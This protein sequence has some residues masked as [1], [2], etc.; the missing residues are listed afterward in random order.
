MSRRACR[1]TRDTSHP[2][3]EQSRGD[4]P[5]SPSDFPPFGAV[6]DSL[7]ATQ[8]LPTW[9]RVGPL[10]RRNNGTVLHGQ[11]PGFLGDRHG[12]FVVD[13]DLRPEQVTVQAIQ[14]AD[15]LSAVRFHTR[16]DLLA[17]FD[18]TRPLLDASGEVRNLDAFYQ[19]AFGLLSSGSDAQSL[20]TL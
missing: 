12:S 1:P 7:R 13:Q 10:M 18:R 3:G 8:D 20:R 5:P 9:V 15:A 11:T 6:L 14:P 4:F 16:R 19:R 17:E 2:P